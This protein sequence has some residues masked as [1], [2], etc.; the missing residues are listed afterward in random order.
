M[1][2]STDTIRLSNKEDEWGQGR[3]MILTERRNTIVMVGGCGAVP[4]WGEHGNVNRIDH[5]ER[6]KRERIRGQTIG[7]EGEFWV[8]L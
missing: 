3:H 4:E 7:I 1:L 5:I 6:G 2:Q 8:E